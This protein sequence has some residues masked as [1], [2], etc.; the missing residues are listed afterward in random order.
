MDKPLVLISWNGKEAPLRCLLADVEPHFELVVF[1][2]S[3]SFGTRTPLPHA[4]PATV[5]SERTECKG[6][7]YQALAR[8]LIA[9]GKRP[10]FVSLID[11]DVIISVGEINRLLHL[12]ECHDLHVFSAA[13]SHDSQYTHRWMLRL[14]NRVMREVDWVEVMMPIYHGDLFISGAPHYDGNVSSWG[15]DKYLMPTL[16]QLCGF[17]RTVIVDAVMASHVRPISSGGSTFRNG[18]TAAMERDRMKQRCLELIRERKPALLDSAWH[19]RIFVRRHVRSRWQ[20]LIYGLGRPV[21][22]W[23][24]QST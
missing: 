9:S 6:D 8:H 18:L 16:Q 2:Y 11:D 14:P 7:I 5:L 22:R 3:G 1:D 19:Q 10:R 12:G 24:D 4:L 15:I 20:Q 17:T 13:L 23:L 21:R